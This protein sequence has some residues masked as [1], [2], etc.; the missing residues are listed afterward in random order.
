MGGYGSGRLGPLLV[1]EEAKGG[2][3]VC[4]P[5]NPRLHMMLVVDIEAIISVPGELNAC[6]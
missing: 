5:N 4:Y 6:F 2:N 3:G 1:I